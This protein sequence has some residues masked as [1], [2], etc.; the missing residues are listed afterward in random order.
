MDDLQEVLD[1]KM[2]LCKAKGLQQLGKQIS[3]ELLHEE[4]ERFKANQGFTCCYREIL[5]QHKVHAQLHRSIGIASAR[6]AKMLRLF[7]EAGLPDCP[8]QC[9]MADIDG[10]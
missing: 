10:V 7:E 2:A 5:D 6:S 1:L 3:N 9:L 8:V 4:E